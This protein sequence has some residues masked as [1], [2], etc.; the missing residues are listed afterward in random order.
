MLQSASSLFGR[1]EWFWLWHGGTAITPAQLFVAYCVRTLC[2]AG[3]A[4]ERRA[5]PAAA[6]LYQKA[7]LH[8]VAARP[9]R[10][11]APRA[12]AAPP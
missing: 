7:R 4:R 5:L 6:S 3:S 9:N 8:A 12:N 10:R 11:R 2:G 1:R